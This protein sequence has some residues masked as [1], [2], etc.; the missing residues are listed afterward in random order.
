MIRK[1]QNRYPFIVLLVIHT[2]LLFFTFYKS[3][4]RKRLL[5]LLFSN[6]G[7]AYIFEYFVLNLFQAYR[8]KPHFLK[9]P[10]MDSLFGAILSQGIYVPFASLF[11]SAFG[12]GW[13]AKLWFSFYFVCVEKLFLKMNVYR[14]NWWKTIYTAFLMPIY[15]ILGDLWYKHLKKGT[16]FVLTASLFLMITVTGV[17]M[18][19]ILSV[20]NQI[21]F[22]WGRFRSWKEHFIVSPLYTILL[23]LFTV[24]SLK[25]NDWMSKSR[26][27][28][29]SMAFGWIIRKVQIVKTKE[30]IVYFNI[31]LHMLWIFLSG[32]YKQWIE[33]LRT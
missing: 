23:S 24:W 19:Y 29:F 30:K 6:I 16:P 20:L 12:L 26:V 33:H 31:P 2:A 25:R 8:Y 14:V 7:F 9:K 28:L 5:I 18:M 27:L 17:N 3:K 4:N 10:F 13:K 22:G 1:K 21:Q 15:F 32:R 11:I